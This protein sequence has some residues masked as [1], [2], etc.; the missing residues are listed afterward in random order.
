MSSP[1][2][3]PSGSPREALVSSTIGFFVGFAA[4]ALF[5]VTAE[6][7]RV[8]MGLG[9]TQVGLLVAMPALSGSLLRIP[10]SA[11]VDTTG[12]RKPFVVLLTLSIAGM[13]GLTAVVTALYPDRMSAGMYPLLLI[14]GLLSGCGIAVFSVGASQVSYWFPRATQGRALAAYAGIGNLAP[15]IFSM[16][17]PFALAGL[18]LSGTYIVWLTLL[19]A[20]TLI[21]SVKGRNSWYFQYRKSGLDPETATLKAAARGQELF[22]SSSLAGGL[23]ISARKWRTWVLVLVYFTSFGGFVSLT[24]W[25][26]TYWTSYFHVAPVVAGLL[27]GLFAILSSGIRIVGGVMSD[28]LRRGGE[29]TAILALLIMLNGAA[30]L[31]LTDKFEVAVPAVLLMAMG[32]GICS[33]AVF[34]MVPQEVP[35]A[36]GGATGWVGGIGAFGGFVIPPIMGYAVRQH[37]EQGYPLGFVTFI[38]LALLGLSITWV[39]KYSDESRETNEAASGRAQ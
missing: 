12:G 37:G 26:P 15:G 18:G 24:A 5:S 17:L 20:G 19:I 16:I 10:F 27:T 8:A 9:P 14:L 23:K 21:Y 13:A 38:V 36:V 11:W 6:R 39:L 33:A 4:V 35:E 28:H 2:A 32:M 3:E 29:N 34:K 31:T 22:P 7:F 1:N 30:L 25:L